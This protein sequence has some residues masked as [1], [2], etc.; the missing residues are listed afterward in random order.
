MLYAR[1]K[2]E[3]WFRGNFP[4]HGMRKGFFFYSLSTNTLGDQKVAES[5]LACGLLEFCHNVFI[6][7]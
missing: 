1:K 3:N 6:E 7:S 4:P 5:E 2:V